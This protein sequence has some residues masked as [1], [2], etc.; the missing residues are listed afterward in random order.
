MPAQLFRVLSYALI[1]AGSVLCGGALAALRPPGP[2]LRSA[3]QHFAVINKAPKKPSLWGMRN[4]VPPSL[5][6]SGI[7]PFLKDYRP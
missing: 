4:S 6:P 2:K 1:P 7:E 5:S 3:V